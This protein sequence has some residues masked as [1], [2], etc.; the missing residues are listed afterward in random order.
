MNKQELE[1]R[2]KLAAEKYYEGNPIMSDEAFDNLVGT[3]TLMDPTNKLLSTPDWGYVSKNKKYAHKY[4]LI[5]SLLKIHSVDE[6]SNMYKDGSIV[7]SPKFDGSTCVAYYVNGKVERALSR[8]DGTEGVDKT[9]KYLKIV[10]KYNLS[11]PETFTGAIRGEIEFTKSNWA[12]YKEK[13]PDAKFPRNV[14]TGMFMSDEISEDLELVDF[15]AY[16]IVGQSEH[17]LNTYSEMLATLNSYGFPKFETIESDSIT[18]EMCE[19]LFQKWSEIYPIDGLVFNKGIE[20]KSNGEYQFTDLAYKLQAETKLANVVG[21]EWALS[22]NNLLIPVVNIEETE[23]SGAVVS[24]VT[25]Y[26]AEY[27]K[28]T[29]LGA[30][31]KIQVQRSGEVIPKIVEVIEADEGNC[32]I[33][34]TCPVC[35][36]TLTMD[37]VHL[38]CNNAMCPNIAHSTLKEWISLIG[39]K[40]VNG[41]GD[42]VLEDFINYYKLTDIDSVYSRIYST[43]VGTPL[44][45]H[46]QKLYTQVVNNLLSDITPAQ[47]LEAMN[48]RGIG[49]EVSSKIADILYENRSDIYEGIAKI[50]TISGIGDAVANL[51]NMNRESICKVFGYDQ[52]KPCE[53]QDVAVNKGI[54]VIVTGSVS[55]P[56]KQFIDY[57]ASYGVKL[58]ETI[59][60]ADVLICNEA[61]N[62]SKYKT[63]Q[64]LGMPILTEAEFKEK[65]LNG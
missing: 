53:T 47:A 31:A 28:A 55:M 59:T 62:S 57:L 32:I 42:S 14:G 17:E 20:Y 34:D 63:A 65:Y 26:N 4:G 19:S 7:V 25:A 8:G 48:I 49:K 38:V 18:D 40:G 37:G 5:G 35:G 56:R 60:K 9:S 54:T 23:L 50:K 1:N 6:L 2:I 30:G 3:L 16:K 44:T 64:K 58:T 22:K 45:E 27:V 13:Y 11:I 12:K 51:I 24:R 41:V 29:N 21:I 15:M 39:C 10:S 61:S 46:Q 52:V 43:Y 36:S 33:P